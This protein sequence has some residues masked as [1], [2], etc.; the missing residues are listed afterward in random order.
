MWFSGKGGR[1]STVIIWYTVLHTCLLVR[2]VSLVHS[3]RCCHS[4]LY[5]SQARP[6]EQHTCFAL[7]SLLIDLLN[8]RSPF[9][10][11]YFCVVIHRCWIGDHFLLQLTQSSTFVKACK[12]GATNCSLYVSAAMFCLPFTHHDTSLLFIIA[13]GLLLNKLALTWDTSCT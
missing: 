11:G 2:I 7:G 10:L 8:S 1:S 6:T 4:L 9:N 12:C 5:V 13:K 3:E